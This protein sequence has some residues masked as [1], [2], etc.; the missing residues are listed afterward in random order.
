MRTLGEIIE[1]A[2]DGQMPTHEECY[3]AILSD[4]ANRPN[5]IFGPEWYWKESFN[6]RKRAYE[7]DPK[8]Y[9]GPNNDPANPDYQKRR[10]IALKICDKAM[11]G[12]LPNQ[13][14]N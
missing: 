10:E 6:R 4:L 14:G 11:K 8:T 12:E 2:K 13:E 3:W 7:K 9:V 5:K 1:S